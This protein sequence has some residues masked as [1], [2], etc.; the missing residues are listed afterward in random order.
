MIE[1]DFGIWATIGCSWYFWKLF[2]AAHQN[3]VASSHGSAG[4]YQTFLNQKTLSRQVLCAEKFA[5][6]LHA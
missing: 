5:N 4:I 3:S 6:F 2:S 1:F